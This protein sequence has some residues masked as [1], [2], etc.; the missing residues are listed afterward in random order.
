MMIVNDWRNENK[1]KINSPMLDVVGNENI[2][3][4]MTFLSTV[5]A[6]RFGHIIGILFVNISC[7]RCFASSSFQFRLPRYGTTPFLFLRCSITAIATEWQHNFWCGRRW[8]Q[9]WRWWHWR[10]QFHITAHAHH[11]EFIIAEIG[12]FR[13]TVV[14]RIVMITVLFWITFFWCY[15]CFIWRIFI[16]FFLLRASMVIKF[17]L[18]VHSD[19]G[20]SCH[21]GNDD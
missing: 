11:T 21:I 4:R 15:R 18:C 7:R 8:G 9:R 6:W 5:I 14:I 12:K 19:V 17:P 2:P 13:R 3:P 1:R 10:W 16:L 20:W